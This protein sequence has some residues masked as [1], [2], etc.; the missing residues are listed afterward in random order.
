MDFWVQEYCLIKKDWVSAKSFTKGVCGGQRVVADTD[1]QAECIFDEF[2]ET[3]K[4]K[5]LAQY[6]LIQS[7]WVGRIYK[8]RIIKTVFIK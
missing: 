5:G 4:G 1:K 6:R 2:I 8:C 3:Q 7:G